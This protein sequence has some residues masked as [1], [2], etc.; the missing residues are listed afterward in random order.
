MLIPELD[1]CLMSP[2]LNGGTCVD[3]EFS[4]T[5]DCESGFTGDKCETGMLT[6]NN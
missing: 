5:C 3:G 6:L 4:F 2:C 1:D